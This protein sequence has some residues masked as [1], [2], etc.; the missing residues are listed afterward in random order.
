M[1]QQHYRCPVCGTLELIGYTVADT[2]RADWPPTCVTCL[3]TRMEMAPQ[4]MLIDARSDGGTGKGFQK[5]TVDV[6]GHP[7][8]IDSLHTLRRVERESE[9]RYRNGEGEPLRFRM[10]HQDHSNRE[11]SAFGTAGTIG[12]RT[13]DSGTPAAPT[14]K[15]GVQRHGQRKPKIRVAKHAGQ[16]PLGGL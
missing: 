6:D 11:V 14:P 8:E 7:T 1:P 5:F 2:R 15:I 13:Y 9:Q 10:W 4:Q 16:S 12:T 3:G